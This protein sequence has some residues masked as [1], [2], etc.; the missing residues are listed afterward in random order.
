ME[1]YIIVF[2]IGLIFGSFLNVLIHR[3]PL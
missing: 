2:I 3:L 1:L